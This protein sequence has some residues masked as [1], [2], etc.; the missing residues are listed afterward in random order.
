MGV[1]VRVCVCVCVS[2]SAGL[3]FRNYVSYTSRKKF[4]HRV[5]LLI[6]LVVYS[7]YMIG[8]SPRQIP[9]HIFMSLA[10]KYSC[11]LVSLPSS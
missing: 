4:A 6:L 7:F 10:N 8:T 1:C 9:V 11:I 5:K 3:Y 2:A